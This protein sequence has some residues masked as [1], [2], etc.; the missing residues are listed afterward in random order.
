MFFT[1]LPDTRTIAEVSRRVIDAARL[2]HFEL[3][4]GEESSAGL[5]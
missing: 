3:L 5:E 1:S 4:L 2:A